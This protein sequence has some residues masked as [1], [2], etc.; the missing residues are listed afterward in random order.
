VTRLL[1]G[2]QDK[3]AGILE[4]T[5]AL[6][7]H[8]QQPAPAGGRLDEVFAE[9][10]ALREENHSLHSLSHAAIEGASA[11]VSGIRD[12]LGQQL[13]EMRDEVEASSAY[14]RR[15]IEQGIQSLAEQSNQTREGFVGRIDEMSLAVSVGD[16]ALRDAMEQGLLRLN[17]GA[18]K[19]DDFDRL[20]REL[21][22]SLGGELRGV[23][24]ATQGT[25]QR[26]LEATRE[27]LGRAVEETNSLVVQTRTEV[28]QL[29]ASEE[30]R[31]ASHVIRIDESLGRVSE[32][33]ALVG[34][35]ISGAQQSLWQHIDD[36]VSG[37]ELTTRIHIDQAVEGA[38]R[39]TRGYIDL[40]AAALPEA[41]AKQLTQSYLIIATSLNEVRGACGDMRL[42]VGDVKA[43]LG[44]AAGDP[45]ARQVVA[46][47]QS[48]RDL[49]KHIQ[50]HFVTVDEQLKKMNEAL[51]VATAGGKT[52]G[53]QA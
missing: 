1:S 24:V 20:G 31:L 4:T 13:A 53:W 35:A 48:M 37:A 32:T 7:E 29:G 19:G 16:R 21:A 11:A 33:I 12:S 5:S 45:I 27:M 9:T 22:A 51:A 49:W 39:A 14:L 2:F 46:L 44:D 8:L 17:E 28:Q 34:K 50:G 30:A 52:S 38:Q 40:A 36:A 43:T 42:A 26:E 41:T 25:L 18:V 47:E 3:L 23:G 10:R 15:A 6:G